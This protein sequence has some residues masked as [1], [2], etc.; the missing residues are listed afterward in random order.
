[1]Q[2]ALERALAECSRLAE[3]FE[4]TLSRQLRAAAGRGDAERELLRATRV[5]LAH[6]LATVVAI[7][8]ELES[9]PM[10]ALR[11]VGSEVSS[12]LSSISLQYLRAQRAAA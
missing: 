4:G 7:E 6:C 9:Q 3:R 12:M 2:Q 1:M 5:S 10:L 8:C 11:S